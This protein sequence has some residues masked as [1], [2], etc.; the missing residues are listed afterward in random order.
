[1]RS[2]YLSI[3]LSLALAATLCAG[4][5]PKDKEFTN[6][7]GMKF[8]QVDPGTLQMGQL[9]PPL[10][11]D[12]LPLFRA[13]GGFEVDIY[14][15]DGELAKAAIRSLLGN[16]CRVGY[17]DK[18]REF[19]TKADRSYNLDNDLRPGKAGSITSDKAISSTGASLRDSMIWMAVPADQV[20]E[21]TC[22]AFRRQFSLPQEPA[23]AQ[24][25]I[26][27]DS[28]YVL[29]V[30]GEYVLQGPCRFNP[31]RPE[32]DTVDVK[33]FLKK[34]S[35]TLAVLVVGGVSIGRIMK[36]EPGLAVQLE[37][38]DLQGKRS[39]IVSD[40]S[41]RCSSQTRYLPPAARGS[42]IRDNIDTTREKADWVLPEFDDSQWS[43]AVDTDGAKW[44]PFYRRSI[45]LLRETDVGP[46]TIVQVTR[47]DRTDN[48]IRPLP[49]ALPVEIKAPAEMV[50]DIGRLAQAYWVLDFEADQGS[51]FTIRP[52]QTFQENKKAD[53][54]FGVVN[55]YKARTGR[56]QYMSTDTFGFRYMHLQLTTGR[57][58]LFG[59]SFVDVTYP[60]DRLGSFEC[61]DTMLNELWDRATYTVQVCSED[62][63]VDCALRE[64]AEWMGD[65]AVV[66]Y[67]ISR[68]AFAGR[69]ENGDYLYGDPRL[70]RN[71]LRHIALSRFDDGRI[72]A[73]ACSDGGDIHS[74]I[75]DYAC[76]WVNTLREYYD[77]T[78][79]IEFVREVWPVLVGQMRWFLDRRTER[80][81]VKA[82]EFL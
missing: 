69:A 67:P 76:L 71:M 75:E 7:I 14:W 45:P 58:T 22:V 53:D 66:T 56:Q 54:N 2:P 52:C 20:Q 8:A 9:G 37:V 38:E 21:E 4:E 33:R 44:G 46:A 82:R 31:K 48:I 24:L 41:W 27:A 47:G 17:A 50:I 73:N 42:C 40:T 29:W 3:A 63:Y 74:Y 72:K 65:G 51:E 43:F 35:N 25:H 16:T 77:N 60:F 15:K 32:Y 28:R 39:T 81:L 12:I 68:I 6:S 79:D 5:V 55:H 26:F 18:T 59:A 13:H 49:Y 23:E 19:T 30:N 64:R 57:M 70:I 78:G 34:G 62:A 10:P 1:M 80:G 61:S 11:S 36:H